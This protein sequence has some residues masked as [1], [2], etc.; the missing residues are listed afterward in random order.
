MP[1]ATLDWIDE[2]T[3]VE[4]PSPA[5]WVPQLFYDPEFRRHV[6]DRLEALS[7]LQA[8]WDGYSA[9]AINP[10]IVT[11]VAAFIAK[12][13]PNIA[14]RPRVVPLAS[15]AVQLEWV[16]DKIALELE[17][18]SPTV[19]HYLKWN[20]AGSVAD[21]DTFAVGDL[22]RAESLIKWFTGQHA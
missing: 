3:A 11:A 6:F 21:E 4:E 7:L 15:G 14:P 17:F 18:E 2:T 9:A 8:G 16:A 19:V 13:R 1:S 12:L 20:P 10:A 5:K 22:D